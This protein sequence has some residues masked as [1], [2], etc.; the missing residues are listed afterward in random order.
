MV[1]GT[2]GLAG[3]GDASGILRVGHLFGIGRLLA[4]GVFLGARLRNVSQV[5]RGW[6]SRLPVSA[7][8]TL[9]EELATV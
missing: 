6:K 1:H 4:F 2:R 9:A 7:A 3:A 5:P 8:L